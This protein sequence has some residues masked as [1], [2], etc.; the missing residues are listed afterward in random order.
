[1]PS[2]WVASR[3]MVGDG[4]KVNDDGHLP[5]QARSTFASHP[6]SSG[7]TFCAHWLSGQLPSGRKLVAHSMGLSNC[8]MVGQRSKSPVYDVPPPL[9]HSHNS[10]AFFHSQLKVERSRLASQSGGFRCL[11]LGFLFTTERDRECPRDCRQ[12]LGARARMCR[13]GLFGVL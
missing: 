7:D 9:P 1:M 6:S 11:K 12:R 10:C 4:A 13:A 8:Q 5:G 2:G 3:S